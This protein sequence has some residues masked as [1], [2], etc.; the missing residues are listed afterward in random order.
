MLS[1]EDKSKA[2]ELQ[3]FLQ[4]RDQVAAQTPR[5]LNTADVLAAADFLAALAE[6]AAARN[7]VRPDARGRADPRHRGRPASGARSGP[8][9]GHVRAQRC[10]LWAARPASFWLIT[11]PNMA[12]KSTFIRQ[13]ALITLMAH[14]GSFVPA[15]S[16]TIGITDRI[17]TRVGASDELSRGQSDVHGRDDRGREHPEQRHAAEP[18]HPRRDRPRHQHLRRRVA[19]LGDH[20]VPA[21]RRRLPLALRHALPRTGAARGKP[22]ATA[23]LQRAGAG[24]RQRG[25]LPAQDRAGQRGQE[26][27]HPR[28]PPRRSCP[29]RCSKRA[30]TVL[31]TLETQPRIAD[32]RSARR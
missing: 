9:A 11:G 26:L 12:G 8:A 1:A 32:A 10:R 20:R 18:R 6:L 15:K 3:L 19:G 21:R 17:F 28:R 7:Y 14:V 24:T 27:R 22:A 31:A 16:A 25:D 23:E 13:V 30:E 29:R 5:L 4:L 2:L